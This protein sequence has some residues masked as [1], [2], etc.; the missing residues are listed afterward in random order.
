MEGPNTFDNFSLT[1]PSCI[2]PSIIMT[3]SNVLVET[4]R[5][6]NLAVEVDGSFPKFQWFKEGTPIIGATS[7]TYDIPRATAQDIGNYFVRVTNCCGAVAESAIMHVDVQSVQPTV[8]R[9][10]AL[11]GGTNLQITFSKPMDANQAFSAGIW[12]PTAY[13]LAAIDGGT[14]RQ[15]ASVVAV[16]NGNTAIVMLDGPLSAAKL[17]QL[18]LDPAITDCSGDSVPPGPYAFQYE[19]CLVSFEGT[20]WKYYTNSGVTP[21]GPQWRLEPNFDDSGWADGVALFDR[22]VGDRD[23]VSGFAVMTKLPLNDPNYESGNSNIPVYLFRTHFNLPI[24]PTNILSLNLFTLSDDVDVCW[25]NNIDLP[26]HTSRRASALITTNA[27][28]NGFGGGGVGDAFPE[29]PFA[30]DP[31][32]LVYGQNLICA[33]QF[34]VSEFSGDITFSYQLIAIVDRFK[35]PDPRIF[36]SLS[37][38]SVNITWSPT[39][40]LLYQADTVATSAANWTVVSGQS[41]GSATAAR[42]GAPKFFTVRQ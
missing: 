3:S 19:L 1:F 34:Q 10:F 17:Y 20:P 13:H 6:A 23:T 8:V 40:G 26:M 22:K 31:T 16:T 32:N 33:K 42:T 11:C 39:N 41:A 12:E 7:R 2:P 35:P 29:G 15:V 9:S 30:I 25:L 21:L 37:E 36:I 27:D 4:C 5:A 28:Y 14:D 18:T 24:A 38:D